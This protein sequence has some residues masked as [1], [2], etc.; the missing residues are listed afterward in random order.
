MPKKEELYTNNI[1]PRYE[2]LEAGGLEELTQAQISSL[3]NANPFYMELGLKIRENGEPEGLGWVP[4]MFVMG[5]DENGH[6]KMKTISETGLKVGSKEFWEQVQM[7][8]V[9][10]YP[11]GANEPVQLQVEASGRRNAKMKYSKPV[12]P[13]ELPQA[14]VQR[15][16]WYH[17]VL[18]FF[19]IGNYR[20]MVQRFDNHQPDHAAIVQKFSSMKEGREG[21]K[22]IETE[23]HEEDYREE[24]ARLEELEKERLRKE[25]EKEEAAL[26]SN[27]ES[28]IR[29]HGQIDRGIYQMT[30]V[31]QPVPQY[32]ASLEKLTEGEAGMNGEIAKQSKAG[33]YLKEDFNKLKVF[34]KDQIDLSKIELG[35]SGKAVTNEEFAAVTFFA[36][37]DN[38][39]MMQTMRTEEPEDIWAKKSLK[40]FGYDEQQA[41]DI[42][43]AQSR[44]W[45][46]ADLFLVPP[47][48]NEG[49]YF[50]KTTNLGREDAVKAFQAY[51]KGDKTKLAGIIAQGLNKAAKDLILEQKNDFSE[52]TK[53]IMASTSLLMDIMKKDPDLETLAKQQGLSDDNLQAAK[54]MAELH[55]IQKDR[56]EAEYKMAKAIQ[57]GKELTAEEKTNLLKPIIKG[58]LTQE[59]MAAD[60]AKNCAEAMNKSMEIG[61]NM[62]MTDRNTQDKWKADPQSRPD[63]GYKRIHMDTY[64][65]VDKGIQK[66]LSP[67]SDTMKNLGTKHGPKHLDAITDEI[68]KQDGLA[69]KPTKD[70]FRDLNENK[71]ESKYNIL[72]AASKASNTIAKN[73]ENAKNAQM[74]QPQANK[75]KEIGNGLGAGL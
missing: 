64:N 48:D 73:M 62:V 25:A 26:R 13:E 71:S 12:K 50:E 10:A 72:S 24:R 53:G 7:G 59:Q 63:P 5:R 37:W 34:G 35:K 68:I 1:Q 31:Y 11:V 43:T 32:D 67:V 47:R 4:R 29:H 52:Q 38:K 56:E 17:R 61:E 23:K 2:S 45:Y 22:E 57:E 28:T 14:P 3:N 70:L 51:E 44:N 30:S 41:E 46:T 16:E 74:D 18:G 42:L 36:L 66:L 6:D 33:L 27:V 58:R 15:V 39:N 65:K 9:F 60:N 8:N 19:R 55:K 54:G 49:S 40:D 69:E 20:E 75:N 21:V